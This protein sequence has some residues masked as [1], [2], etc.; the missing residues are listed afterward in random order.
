MNSNIHER[1]PSSLSTALAVRPSQSQPAYTSFMDLLVEVLDQIFAP[2]FAT[3]ASMLPLRAVSQDLLKYVHNT[4]G[5]SAAAAT[6]YPG[7]FAYRMKKAAS[8]GVPEVPSQLLRSLREA[9]LFEVPDLFETPQALA[10]LL[11]PLTSLE[12]IVLHPRWFQAPHLD[13]ITHAVK[14][15]EALH[16]L[17]VTAGQTVAYVPHA[18]N[19][20]WESHSAS[21]QTFTG[22]RGLVEALA[23][24]P[25]GSLF[26]D[27]Y[28]SA[29]NMQKLFAHVMP[30]QPSL[31]GMM[32][33]MPGQLAHDDAQTFIANING[34]SQL[35]ELRLHPGHQ[36][37]TRDS[38][39]AQLGRM[40][41]VLAQRPHPLQ[42][43]DVNAYVFSREVTIALLETHRGGLSKVERIACSL[44]QRYDLPEAELSDSLRA[45]VRPQFVDVSGTPNAPLNLAPPNALRLGTDDP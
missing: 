19:F 4:P 3:T 2:A 27:Y 11:A 18:D 6:L 37:A 1:T 36:R 40:L 33:R 39:A 44:Q 45:S 14:N 34:W 13:A 24:K 32:L 22:V 8:R 31:T 29:E 17:H 35:R 16:S 41:D 38:G 26:L 23:Q 30:K 9:H 10:H 25:G 20:D 28:V 43:L 15:V 12:R 42:V 21:E 5:F 7:A